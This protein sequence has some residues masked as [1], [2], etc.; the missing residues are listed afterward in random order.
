MACSLLDQLPF[1][2]RRHPDMYI[3]IAVLSKIASEQIRGEDVVSAVIAISQAAEEEMGG[4][5]GALYSY[6]SSS[7]SPGSGWSNC[8]FITAYS[9]PLSPKA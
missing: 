8:R 9:S 1:E 6:V 2:L 7:C 3:F 4:T 5:S